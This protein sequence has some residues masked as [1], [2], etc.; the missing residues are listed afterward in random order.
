LLPAAGYRTPDAPTVEPLPSTGTP[1]QD[2]RAPVEA[3]GGASAAALRDLGTSFEKASASWERITDEHDKVTALEARTKAD[4]AANDVLY[5]DINDPT[6]TG[7]FGLEG[8]AKLAARQDTVKSLRTIYD[9]A[10]K[11]L[12]PS[13]KR[14]YDQSTRGHRL[15]IEA[16]IALDSVKA[17]TE[18]RKEADKGAVTLAGQN[19][20]RL[21]L[22]NDL[23]AWNASVGE[24]VQIIQAA[25][26]RA[27]LPPE[28]IEANKNTFRANRITEKAGALME[29]DPAAALEFID[30]NSRF[31]ADP[32][33]LEAIRGRAKEKLEARQVDQ[34][35]APGG[36]PRAGATATGLVPH[37]PATDFLTG[38]GLTADQYQTFRSHLASRESGSYAQPPNRG[39]YAG[40]YQMGRTEIQETAERL[41]VPVPS[42]QEF[43]SNPELQERFLENYTLDHH[44]QL[45]E[46]SETYRKARP[47]VKAAFL[48]GAHLGGVAG[49]VKYLESNGKIDPADSNG[50]H[51]SDYIGSMRLA[52]GRATQTSTAP[53]GP[54]KIVAGGDSIGVGLNQNNKLEGTSAGSVASPEG[55]LADAA[56]SR[57]PQQGLDYI[58]THPERFA[59]KN[60]LWSTGL[61]NAGGPEAAKAALG[62][63][64]EQID[65][66]KAAG[67]ANVVLVG[68]DTGRFAFLNPELERIAAEKGVKFAGPLPTD[69]IHP[70]PQGY[71]DYYA[72]ASKLF[73]TTPPASGAPPGLADEIARIQASPYSQEVKDKAI[74]RVNGR[75]SQQAHV[76]EQNED[77]LKRRV[78]DG[79]PS[80][81]E[82]YLDAQMDAGLIGPSQRQSVEA[83]R[84]GVLKGQKEKSD[85]LAL[86]FG[87][88]SG[89]AP[90]DPQNSVHKKAVNDHFDELSKGV[91]PVGTLPSPEVWNSAINYTIKLGMV[92]ER[93]RSTIRGGL[94]SGRPDLALRAV[95][96]INTL[97]NVNPQLVAEIGDENDM[98]L[99]TL[100]GT[101]AGSG[102]APEQAVERANE[103]LKVSKPERDAR[104]ADYDL[105]RGKE[106]KD[107]TASDEKWISNQNNSW[108]P[109]DP[110]ID[111]I[112][113][114]E[115]SET[116][117][118]EYMRTGNLEASRR[119]ALDTVNR[120]WGRSEVGGERRYVKQAPEKFYSIPSLTPAENSAWMNEQ[121]L[122]DVGKGAL[123]DPA[124]PIT[125]ERLRLI[126][127]PTRTNGGNPVYQVWLVQPNKGW[128]QV[129]DTKGAPIRWHPDYSTSADRKRRDDAAAAE[130]EKA[131]TLRREQGEREQMVPADRPDRPNRYRTGP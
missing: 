16:N 120:V 43:L 42:Q 86:V 129:I 39:G 112:M 52:M 28:T 69:N 18:Y 61:F 75:Y 116:A 131:R 76:W 5:G 57:N 20:D 8:R 53:S 14:L 128:E 21:A 71:R 121:L 58:K 38:T 44:N 33:M 109:G 119:M 110:N 93:V 62:K 3:F 26:E 7:Y 72:T 34:L 65:A 59:G 2:I 88:T 78:R 10:A 29:R 98:R 46:Q 15:G 77:A 90:L 80:V 74:A 60:V 96:T 35:A 23:A 100:I 79:D 64:G 123:Q 130:L 103:A 40:R 117:K 37:T 101:Y 95:E 114:T 99:A 30:N 25:G 54:A 108:L 6:S 82:P 73:T 124:N 63:V 45:M 111:P 49:V 102:M 19:A 85:N 84:Q 32:S 87:A 125:S 22:T 17:L 105:Q 91:W 56:G 55:A 50:T 107:R 115:F 36:G 31:Y 51:V 1:F 68:L 47:E 48:M 41:K 70:S 67:A 27:N 122:S 104:A 113:R 13:A 11:E 92:P 9:D 106:P 66:L 97:R 126:P 118:A 4:L 89:G 127:D 24:G 94:H 12:S 83:Y 81:T